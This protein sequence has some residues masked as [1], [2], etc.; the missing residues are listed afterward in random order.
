MCVSVSMLRVHVSLRM[1]SAR[2]HAPRMDPDAY[3]A[4]I[5]VLMLSMLS[6]ADGDARARRAAGPVR[7]FEHACPRCMHV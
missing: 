1:V 7:A 4:C 6:S 5:Y 2:E 3:I